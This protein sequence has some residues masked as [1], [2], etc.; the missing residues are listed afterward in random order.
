[1]QTSVTRNFLREFHSILHRNAETGGARP[2]SG[3]TFSW[4]GGGGSFIDPNMWQDL[5]DPTQTGTLFPTGADTA[6]FSSDGDVSD[7]AQV[8]SLEIDATVSFAGAVDTADTLTVSAFNTL[9]ANGGF[10]LFGLSLDGTMTGGATG[11]LEGDS[12]IND[13]ASLDMTGAHVDF[14]VTQTLTVAGTVSGAFRLL[15]SGDIEISGNGSLTTHSNSSSFSIAGAI[16]VG[17]ASVDFDRATIDVS[18]GG[19]IE[20]DSAVLGAQIEEGLGVIDAA[21]W[22]NAH[23]FTVGGSDLGTLIVKNA[24]TLDTSSLDISPVG[25]G[26]SATITDVGSVVMTSGGLVVAQGGSLLVTA[27]AHLDNQDSPAEIGKIVSNARSSADPVVQ[28]TDAGSWDVGAITLGPGTI[29]VKDGTINSASLVIGEFTGDSGVATADG[30]QSSWTNTG[31]ITVGRA[32]DGTLAL[33]AGASLQ[34]GGEVEAGASATGTG[35]ITVS[36]AGTTLEITGT[37]TI[38]N[39]GTATMTVDTGGFATMAGLII[40][41]DTTSGSDSSPDIV[42]A[43]GAGSSLE[44][45]G[46]ATIDTATPI[47]D[48]GN[49]DFGLWAYTDSG[50]GQLT[51]ANGGMVSIGGTL[52]LQAPDGTNDPATVMISAGGGIEVGGSGGGVGDA[53]SVDAGGLVTGHGTI[54]ALSGAVTVADGGTVEAKEG[55]LDIA[56]GVSGAGFTIDQD[57]TLRIEGTADSTTVVSFPTADGTPPTDYSTTLVLDDPQDFAGEIT[58]FTQGDTIWLP[59]F[60][61]SSALVGVNSFTDGVSI[62][63]VGSLNLT[64]SDPV[65]TIGFKADPNGGTDL[66]TVNVQTLLDLAMDTYHAPFAGADGYDQF[67]VAPADAGFE[68]VAYKDSDPHDGD[69]SIVIAFRGTFLNTL[70]SLVKNILADTSFLFATPNALLQRYI[71]DAVNFTASIVGA[72][73]NAQIMLTGHSLGG[74]IAQ[75]IGEVS[76]LGTAAFNAPGTGQIFDALQG[77]LAPAVNLGDG[78]TNINYRVTGDQA[79]FAGT[80]ARQTWSVPSTVGTSGATPAATAAAQVLTNHLSF[81][82]MQGATYTEGFTAPDFIGA[83]QQA[84]QGT[85]GGLV[86]N[87]SLNVIAGVIN[88]LDPAA[89]SSFTLTGD[90]GSPDISA[91]VLPVE[92]AVANYDVSWVIGGVSSSPTLVAPGVS[93]DLPAGVTAFTFDPVD[94]ADAPVVIPS[95]FY[96]GLAFATTGAFNGTLTESNATPFGGPV[97]STDTITLLPAQGPL[98]LGIPVP[99]DAA[100]ANPADLGALVTGLPGNGTITLADGI[101]P[102]TLDEALTIAQLTGLEVTAAADAAHTSSAFTYTITDPAFASADGAAAIEVACFCAGTRILTDAGEVPVEALGVADR[103]VSLTHQRPLPV[104]WIGSRAV[105]DATPVRIAAGAFGGGVPR[106]TL[107][108]SPDH[109]VFVG[110]ALVP[111]RYLINGTTITQHAVPET[112]YYH[113]ELASHALLLADGLPAES[114]LDTGNRAAFADSRA[115]IPVSRSTA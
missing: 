61:P 112:T 5:T 53:L 68:A 94:A 37:T 98:P 89:G 108:L 97:T 107:R 44:V 24:G 114:Y 115:Q 19:S 39:A 102:V 73:P 14:G 93:F 16:V 63:G 23:G 72:N 103:V 38:G 7:S 21:H 84:A 30:A 17:V 104:R 96:L 43:D 40:A 64:G 100:D 101:T 47:L 113:V 32:G 95:G 36:D 9:N 41:A 65:P 78:G 75:L 87:I 4:N 76:G 62:Q 45:T 27:N 15:D 81:P 71:V 109:A 48:P 67:A 3:D 31:D 57:A 13:G 28:V 11:Y 91:I 66:E 18:A 50:I 29:E 92:P 69:P 60:T 74:G 88:L 106:R 56:A 59:N 6:I 86:L 51:A 85:G 82:G 35:T 20:S 8:G 25:P 1:L 54:S 55:T 90:P 79:S 58:N 10:T 77:Q 52:T 22:T 46:D 33:K 99:T 80:P 105:R 34:V 70:Q 2:M 83:L 110:R 49:G 111:V 12:A 42:A 26:G